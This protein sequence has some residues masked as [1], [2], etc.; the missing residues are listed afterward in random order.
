MPNWTVRIA[1]SPDDIA[2]VTSFFGEIK[3]EE[4]RAYCERRLAHLRYRPEFTRFIELDGRLVSAALLRHDRWLVDGEAL[5][6]GF[7]ENI[8]THPEHRGQGLFTALLHDCLRFLRGERFPLAWLHGA[9]SRYAPFGFAPVRHHAQ[10]TLPAQVA[11]GLPL[12]GRARPFTAEDLA[13]VAAL[14]AATY[15][16]LT[17]SEE[18]T[19]GVWHW[20][21]PTMNDVMVLEDTSGLVAGYAWVEQRSVQRKLRVIEAAAA[22]DGRAAAS[23]LS[24]LGARAQAAGLDSVYLPLPPEH[25]LA[26]AVVLAGGEARLVGPVVRESR[27]GHA[28]QAQVLDLDAALT[29]LAPVLTRRL[30]NSVYADWQGNIAIDTDQGSASLEINAGAVQAAPRDG[31]TQGVLR[32][33]ANLLAPL[34]VGTYSA[35][36]LTTRAGFEAPMPLLAILDVLFPGRWPTTENED[37]WIE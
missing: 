8:L 14:Y 12:V 18:R 32:L 15:K 22:P 11:A 25:P 19:A 6:A 4:E 16:R 36:E 35:R 17:T 21:L 23:L 27:W 10:A 24:I 7:L 3:G 20:L 2:R 26:R 34:F 5:D 37:W 31:V 9:I 30:A 33:P 1:E 28:D 29:A 13:D